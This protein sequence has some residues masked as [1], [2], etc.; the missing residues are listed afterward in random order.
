MK[1]KWGALVVDGRNKIGGHVAS[2]NRA[3]A[4]LR[5]KVTPVNPNTTYQ[6]GVRQR[7][8]GLAIAFRALSAADR[9]RWICAVADWKTTDIFG[10]LKMPSGFNLYCKLN[11]NLLLAGATAI[12]VPPLPLLVGAVTTLTPTQVHAGVTSITY[13]PTPT[14]ALHQ[15]IVRA[16]RPLSAGKTFVKSELRIIGQLAPATATPYVATGDYATKFGGP[17]AAGQ[18]VFFEAFFIHLTTGQA[19]P[20]TLA[21]CIVT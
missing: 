5:S 18:K 21:S 17:G 16:T 1:I 11:A 7:L 10:D 3:G 13:A 2:R 12:S 8:K 20:R 19:G 14:T 4:Y 9:Q 6:V 15:M